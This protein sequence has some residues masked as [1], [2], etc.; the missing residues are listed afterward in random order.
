[1]SRIITAFCILLIIS[2]DDATVSKKPDALVFVS[3]ERSE[4]IQQAV[5][6]LNDGAVDRTYAT[7]DASFVLHDDDLTTVHEALASL[8]PEKECVEP[9]G[10]PAELL[11]TYKR[12]TVTTVCGAETL[13]KT[14]DAFLLLPDHTMLWPFKPQDE[15]HPVGHTAI[16]FQD[17]S[18]L[19]GDEYFHPGTDI[20]MPENST[21]YNILPGRVIRADYYDLSGGSSQN[22]MYFEVVIETQNGLT[23]QYHHIDPD[24]VSDA[25]KSAK[26]S[27]AVLPAGAEIGYIVSWTV[28]ET[29]YSN[30]LFHHLHLNIFT[31]DLLPLNG[32]QM[33]IPHPDTV[34][35]VIESVT[36]LD[37][38]LSTVIDPATLD[39]DFHV[40]FEG[41]DMLDDNVWPLPPRHYTVTVKDAAGK[42]ILERKSYDYLAALSPVKEDFVCDHYLCGVAGMASVGNYGTRTMFI[43]VTAFDEAGS[44]APPIAVADLDTGE[45]T[46]SLTACD[47]Y[48]NCT[49]RDTAVTIP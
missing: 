11:V 15:S 48:D 39:G 16:S 23:L 35:P 22:R 25:V 47:Q 28:V 4:G 12:G 27:G 42:T 41:Y 40:V 5:L 29:G 37:E 17:Y 36:L 30:E 32:L 20:I 38:T 45:K 10:D 2:C 1:M 49:S 43:N 7:A 6:Y 34:P 3:I 14:V 8:D 44:L 33:L 13:K 18:P 19:A 26:Q 31:R 46:L 9:T 21:V 24:S